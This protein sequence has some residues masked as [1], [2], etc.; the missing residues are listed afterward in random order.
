[1]K[2]AEKITRFL[3]NASVS[4]NPDTNRMVFDELS[5]EMKRSK[6]SGQGLDIWRIIMKSKMTKI[7]VAAVVFIAIILGTLPFAGKNGFSG[8]AWGQMLETMNQMQWVQVVT[9]TEGHEGINE[10]WTCLSPQIEVTISID[11]QINYKAYDKKKEYIYNPETNT[12]TIKPLTDKYNLIR[13][14][15]D[16]VFSLLSFILENLYE[17][18]EISSEFSKIEGRDVEIISTTKSNEEFFQQ[19]TLYR[20]IERNLLVQI[21]INTTVSIEPP[22]E[23]SQKIVS[24]DSSGPEA[25]GNEKTRTFKSSSTLYYPEKGPE[26]IYDLSVPDDA[27]VVDICPGL[28]IK[29]VLDIIE[30][31]YDRNFGSHLAMVL[32]S[33]IEEDGT[34][35]PSTII[36]VRQQ[37]SSQRMDTYFAGNIE[38]F[39][40]LNEHIRDNWSALTI[41]QVL[42]IEQNKA[43]E[44]Q[45]I[46][47]GTN[48]TVKIRSSRDQLDSHKTRGKL[49]FSQ[50]DSMASLAWFDPTFLFQNTRGYNID[51]DL[52]E[53]DPEHQGLVGIRI[54]RT[55]QTV[56]SNIKIDEYWLDPQR[57]YLV[58]QEYK[59]M[60]NAGR[61][62]TSVS[63]TTMVESQQAANGQWY[64][65]HI[66]YQWNYTDSTG[67]HEQ[68]KDKRIMLDTNPQ[69]PEGIFEAD[70]E[71]NLP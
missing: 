15:P 66:I 69:F 53:N 19:Y 56:P 28:E 10:Q 30:S 26:S 4:S 40:N 52:I 23:I 29:G 42:M 43:T 54:T 33:W 16:S 55:N 67:D 50:G 34:L 21:D 11:G 18:T 37:D 1:M 14:K 57:D 58:V 22:V 59:K 5:E 27:I 47:D 2:D 20:D 32:E 9:Q 36:M 62:K 44:R 25:S 51:Y 60:E 64:P 38:R 45:L 39:E 61:Y 17:N 3:K 8:K 6:D 48:S 41:Q 31:N 7:A 35:D 49:P 70:Y 12:I 68:K 13:S 71:F 63:N 24:K 46:F 65:S